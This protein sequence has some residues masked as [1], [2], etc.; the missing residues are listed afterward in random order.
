M[1][2]SSMKVVLA[3]FGLLHIQGSKLRTD[4]PSSRKSYRQ[5]LQNH[6][7]MQYFAKFEIGDQPI[8]AIFDTGSFEVVVRSSR[9]VACAHPTHP[10][11]HE[12][13][14]S[15]VENGTLE[16]HAYGS[17]TCTTMLGYDTVKVGPMLAPSQPIWE[18]VSHEIP[19]LDKAKFAAIVGIGPKLGYNSQQ[20]TLLMNFHI[21][22][23]SIC[24]QKEPGSDGYLVWGPDADEDMPA[25]QTVL[26]KVYGNHHW[27]TKM[28]MV[29]VDKLED[30]EEKPDK[31]D[32][33]GIT[34]PSEALWGK[35]ND[36]ETNGDEEEEDAPE[37]ICAH[38]CAAIIDSGTSLIAGPSTALYMLKETI[39]EVKEDCSNIHTLPNLRFNLDGHILELPP[40]AYVMRTTGASLDA[41]T[42]WDLLFFKP[43]VRKLDVCMLGFM[44]MDM[45]TSVGDVWIF[46]MPFFRFFHSTFDREKQVMRF[47]KAG[48][49]CYPEPLEPSKKSTKGG[50][51]FF[52]EKKL[53]AS[54]YRPMDVDLSI[55]MPP[56]MLMQ[57]FDKEKHV[58]EL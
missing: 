5:V 56:R 10:Y 1:A 34:P 8:A 3:L 31:D 27:A 30:F 16:N 23:F 20:K 48:K 25:E 7:D 43:K 37:V 18:I 41:S 35:G 54:A 12:M 51:L 57:N 13:S 58:L 39:G 52:S 28:T 42:V 44:E 55:V 33:H 11:T 24:L 2:S 22:E 50:N 36:E 14:T 53:D 32:E 45:T 6:Q 40:A 9:C 17:G 47:A 4:D 29:S 26:V 38:G 49:D 46:G 21:D 15:F 19:I